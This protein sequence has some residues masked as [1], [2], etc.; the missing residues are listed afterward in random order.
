MNYTYVG[1]VLVRLDGAVLAQHRDNNPSIPEPDTWG[2]CGGKREDDDSTDEIGACR[3]LF[4]ETGY[5]I[6]PDELV[7]LAEDS[8]IAGRHHIT[9]KFYWAPYDG[10]QQ[11]SCFE[12]QEIRFV[13]PSELQKLIFCEEYH[14]D[15]LRRANREFYAKLGE[16]N[17][18]AIK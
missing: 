10:K 8:F 1:I 9:R 13:M 12:G 17:K 11:I 2:I 14:R 5:H 4:E 18:Q 16:G 3:E 15:Y 7:S 6:S